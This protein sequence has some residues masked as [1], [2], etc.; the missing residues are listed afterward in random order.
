[1]KKISLIESTIKKLFFEESKEETQLEYMERRILETKDPLH[2]DSSI[3]IFEAILEK[4]RKTGNLTNEFI[5]KEIEGI[6]KFGGYVGCE[7]LPLPATFLNS[8]IIR[9]F[10]KDLSDSKFIGLVNSR[11]SLEYSRG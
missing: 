6:F 9:N 3:K 11:Y 2:I 7:C 10:R 4:A 8:F 1:M 5:D